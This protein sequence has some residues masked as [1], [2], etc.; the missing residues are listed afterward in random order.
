M[1]SKIHQP[2]TVLLNS[3]AHAVHIDDTVKGKD[4]MKPYFLGSSS[5]SIYAHGGTFYGTGLIY[6]QIIKFL[7][8]ALNAHSNTKE[9]ILH[10]IFLA[11]G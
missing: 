4:I 8:D 11:L 5:S 7:L 3:I 10:G 2:G 9:A 1:G 6:E